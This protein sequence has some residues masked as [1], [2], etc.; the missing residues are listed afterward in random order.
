MSQLHDVTRALFRYPHTHLIQCFSKSGTSLLIWMQFRR[1]L[2]Y[3]AVYFDSQLR[4]VGKFS[5]LPLYKNEYVKLVLE[6][7]GST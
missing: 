6:D 1:H 2:F 7:V 5:T 4:R 3:C